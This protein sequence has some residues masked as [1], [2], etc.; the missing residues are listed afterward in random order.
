MVWVLVVQ[1]HYHLSYALDQALQTKLDKTKIGQIAHNAE[2]NCK[3]GLG[4]VL[5]SFSRGI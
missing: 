3:T 5:A 1:L 4:D 2:V